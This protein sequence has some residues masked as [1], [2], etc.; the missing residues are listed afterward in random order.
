M[1]KIYIT[2]IDK[3][4]KEFES[5]SYNSVKYKNIQNEILY[6]LRLLYILKILK[7]ID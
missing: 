2:K 7:F 4:R 5:C 1:V 6:I 3:N